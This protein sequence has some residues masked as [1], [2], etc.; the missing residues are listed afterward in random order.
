MTRLTFQNTSHHFNL[1]LGDG[2]RTRASCSRKTRSSSPIRS[3]DSRASYHRPG[4]L[5]L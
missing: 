4:L 1:D 5:A 2:E 3:I